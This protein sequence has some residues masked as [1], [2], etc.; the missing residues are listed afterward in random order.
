LFVPLVEE[1]WLDGEV[2]Q[3]VAEQYLDPLASQGIDTLV[4]G[5]TH[6]PLLKPVLQRILGDGVVL[7][8]SAEETAKAVRGNL[9]RQG[10]ENE[11]DSE[12]ERFFFVSDIPHHF[13]RV[14]EMCLG[15]AIKSVT[16]VDLD[17]MALESTMEQ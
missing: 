5:C 16:R 3:R 9:I 7:I 12:P 10:M 13:Q 2:T 1:G 11:P 4:L 8:D 17:A 15:Q 6:Y 14:G